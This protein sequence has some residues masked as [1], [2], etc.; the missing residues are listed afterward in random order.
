[1][2]R[3]DYRDTENRD[4]SFASSNHPGVPA[5]P[6]L[7]LLI[8]I[9]ICNT[10]GP[11]DMI[12]LYACPT[13]HHFP[14]VLVRPREREMRD[15]KYH[16]PGVRSDRREPRDLAMVADRCHSYDVGMI[17]SQNRFIYSTTLAPLR[18]LSYHFSAIREISKASR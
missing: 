7:A 10:Q 4:T 13:A 16:A 6:C 3:S 2:I 1:M 5:L 17:P 11:S 12:C 18:K 15:D 9:A 14:L 8:S